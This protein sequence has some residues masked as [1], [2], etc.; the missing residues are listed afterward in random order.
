MRSFY[1][2]DYPPLLKSLRAQK[3]SPRYLE[4]LDHLPNT[5][6]LVT[7]HPGT[8]AYTAP[9]RLM[10]IFAEAEAA[11]QPSCQSSGSRGGSLD[12]NAAK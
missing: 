4:K 1:S 11:R 7:L 2:S 3:S 8:S 12:V 5:A 6:F 10:S 9:W